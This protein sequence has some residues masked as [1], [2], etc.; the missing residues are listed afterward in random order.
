M[1]WCLCF[2]N[3][4]GYWLGMFVM[5]VTVSKSIDSNTVLE[6][7]R[8]IQELNLQQVN[9]GSRKDVIGRHL[10]WVLGIRDEFSE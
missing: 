4:V 5:K 6:M 8:E 7:Q 3:S 9:Q 10:A 1:L 2:S